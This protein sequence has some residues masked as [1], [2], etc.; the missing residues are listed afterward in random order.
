MSMIQGSSVL[1]TGGAGFLGR[2]LTK[3]LLRRRVRKVVIYSRDEHKHELMKEY[4]KD[5][6][7]RLRFIVADVLD[8]D[9]LKY[10]IRGVDYVI[11]G[12]ALKIIPT[13]Q[14]SPLK[15]IDVNMLGWTSVVKAVLEQNEISGR[16]IRVL[17]I[18]SDKA[19][20]PLN[21]YGKAKALGED[22]FTH[23][24]VY[25]PNWKFS[26]VRFGNVVGSTSS[27]VAAKKLPGLTHVDMTRF[28]IPIKEAVD[29][30]LYALE[31]MFGGE[32]FVPKCRACRIHDLMK[33]LTGKT[34]FENI[35]MRPGEKIDEVL[36]SRWEMPRTIG[37]D[38][39]YIILPE[40]FAQ[41]GH[42]YHTSDYVVPFEYSSGNEDLRMTKE[43]MGAMFNVDRERDTTVG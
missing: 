18:S 2:H 39:C 26:S 40:E 15:Y 28:F 16:Y 3:E 27:L 1:I 11:H 5:D 12:A 35:G 43:E 10:A 8:T 22:L 37:Q 41:T 29:L 17:G 24:N 32:I 20:E 23:G 7:G 30:T 33:L 13:G 31:G 38:D 25:S 9:Y 14:Y 4:F 42:H 34:K 21:T 36:I 19:V 6:I